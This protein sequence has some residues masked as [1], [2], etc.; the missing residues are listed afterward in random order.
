MYDRV[1]AALSFGASQCEATLTES[2][3]IW[4]YGPASRIAEVGS[5]VALSGVGQ[6]A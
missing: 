6:R 4:T 1:T 5:D 3:V 2:F